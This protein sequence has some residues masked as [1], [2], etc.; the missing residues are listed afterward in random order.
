MVAILQIF[1]KPSQKFNIMVVLTFDD[2]QY[3]TMTRPV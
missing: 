3:V 1:S 2:I